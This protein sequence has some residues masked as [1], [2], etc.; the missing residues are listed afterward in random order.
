MF[1]VPAIGFPS[2]AE[3]THAVLLVKPNGQVVLKDTL[4]AVELWDFTGVRFQIGG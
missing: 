4:D 3:P 1:A 2:T